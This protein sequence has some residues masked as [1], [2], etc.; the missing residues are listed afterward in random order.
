MTD[1]RIRRIGNT[2]V[3]AAGA[4]YSP[5]VKGR[6]L[7]TLKNTGNGYVAYFPSHS[8][9]VQ[10]NFICLDYDEARLLILGLSMFKTDLGFGAAK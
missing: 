3:I 4:G 1:E 5:H 8:S 7:C 10:E 6:N 9:C 2:A